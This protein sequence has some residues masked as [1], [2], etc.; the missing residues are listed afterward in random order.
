MIFVFDLDYTLFNA[1][2]FKKKLARVLGFKEKDFILS[3][4]KYFK[5]DNKNY[6][7]ERHLKIM[8][9]EGIIINYQKTKKRVTDFFKT[10]N[11]YVFPGVES[12]LEALKKNGHLLFLLSYGD[13]CWQ[14]LKINNLDIKK[15]FDKIIIA[16]QAKNKRLDFINNK[17]SDL[18]IINDNAK[19]SL[20]LK[21]ALGRGE[22]FLIKG[23]YSNNIKHNLKIYKLKDCLTLCG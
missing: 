14:R 23:P 17:T 2:N 6:N 10:I 12:A 11:V 20:A 1:N 21:K 5:E 8:Q 19:E 16:E 18:I 4:N 7:I 9:Q 15:Y 13:L 3:Y 22:I